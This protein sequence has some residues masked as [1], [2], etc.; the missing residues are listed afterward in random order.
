MITLICGDQ[1]KECTEEEASRILYIQSK[2]KATKWQID[3]NDRTD[4]AVSKGKTSQKRVK[5]GDSTSE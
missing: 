2:M 1:V 4:T 5:S 3:V